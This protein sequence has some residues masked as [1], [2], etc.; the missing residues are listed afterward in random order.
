MSDRP[1][2]AQADA[3]LAAIDATKVYV[4]PP[5]ATV[6]M[7]HAGHGRVDIAAE[8]IAAAELAAESFTDPHGMH[9][10]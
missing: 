9:G 4:L 6:V 1:T 8:D 5:G 7:L 10:L 2:D 3:L